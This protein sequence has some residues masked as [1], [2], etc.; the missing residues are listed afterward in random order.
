MQLAGKVAIVTGANQGIGRTIALNL[1]NA[2]ADIVAVDL[3]MNEQTES[4]TQELE[5]L[6]RKC[7][8]L[9]ADVSKEDDVT[10]FVKE[11]TAQ[12]ASLVLGVADRRTPRILDEVRAVAGALPG[13]TLLIGEQASDRARPFAGARSGR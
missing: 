3:F 1:A 2:G 13:A 7:L 10:A 6:E 5:K 8:P 11:A 12:D 9:Q 4:L